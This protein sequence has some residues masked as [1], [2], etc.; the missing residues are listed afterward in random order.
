MKLGAGARP[1]SSGPVQSRF[2]FSPVSSPLPPWSLTA[3]GSAMDRIRM[4]F[5]KLYFVH[6][7]QLPSLHL[8]WLQ[9][10]YL[11]IQ[12]EDD[13]ITAIRGTEF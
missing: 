11:E 2:L 5:F 6:K 4:C 1:C 13:E 10:L 9:V 7:T 3:A 12:R 8:T